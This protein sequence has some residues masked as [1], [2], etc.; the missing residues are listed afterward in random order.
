MALYQIDNVS[1]P[2][3]W[4]ES[5]PIARTVQNAKNLLMCQMGEVPYQRLLGLDQTIYDLP[6]GKMR[7]EL[8]PALDKCM[9]WEPD[10]EVVEA[11]ATVMTDGKVYIRCVV[12]VTIEEGSEVTEG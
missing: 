3:N 7:Q 12:D 9:M 8:L 6:M 5:D 10:V 4:Q 1:A 11:E 2:I